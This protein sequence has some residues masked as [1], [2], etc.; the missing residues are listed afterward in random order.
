MPKQLTFNPRVKVR[1]GT[2]DMKSEPLNDDV[3]VLVNLAS[4]PS[5]QQANTQATIMYSVFVILAFAVIATWLAALIKMGMCGGAGSGYFWATLLL[6]F[7]P[8]PGTLA[9]FVM[10]IIALVMIKPG[11][12]ALGITCPSTSNSK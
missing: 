10:A 8:G 1:Q 11:K 2:V 7:L 9:A 5:G 6:F 12:T 4:N 3:D